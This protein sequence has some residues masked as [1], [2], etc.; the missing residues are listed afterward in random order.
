MTAKSRAETAQHNDDN[1]IKHAEF[2][3]IKKKKKK[4]DDN[5]RFHF[6]YLASKYFSK[7][8][9]FYPSVV[10]ARDP[11]KKQKKNI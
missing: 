3:S 9:Y 7:S 5:F 4:T 11:T 10:L 8:Q 6:L 2:Y 1:G